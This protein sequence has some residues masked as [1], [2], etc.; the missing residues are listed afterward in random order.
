ML[1]PCPAAT[2]L[3]PPRTPSRGKER[4]RS[5]PRRLF[6]DL[7]A[8]V[9]NPTLSAGRLLPRQGAEAGIDL[10]EEARQVDRLG[11]EIGA[12]D[13]D[14]LVAIAGQRVRGERDDRDVGGRRV[15][16]D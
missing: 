1:C 15:G 8:L 13:F 11:V 14:A 9:V 5:A 16:F 7:A 2:L 3:L 4:L 10:A 6:A 12:A